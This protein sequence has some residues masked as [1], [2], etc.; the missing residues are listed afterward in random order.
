MERTGGRPHWACRR[1][2][3]PYHIAAGF[4]HR[5]FQQVAGDFEVLRFGASL[6]IGLAGLP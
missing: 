6:G 5:D 3:D 1:D 2:P 4:A